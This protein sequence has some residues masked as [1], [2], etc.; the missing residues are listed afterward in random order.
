MKMTKACVGRTAL[1]VGKKAVTDYRIPLLTVLLFAFMA[2]SVDK[3]STPY[4]VYSIL[5]SVASSGIA[6]IGFTFILLLYIKI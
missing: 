2:M 4:N 6:A 5:D 1:T 3:F